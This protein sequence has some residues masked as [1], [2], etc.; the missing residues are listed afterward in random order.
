MNKFQKSQSKKIKSCYS[1]EL[2]KGT[3]IDHKYIRKEGKRYVYEESSSKSKQNIATD[4]NR[5]YRNIDTISSENKDELLN[6]AIKWATNLITER[7][8]I[9]PKFTIKWG[10]TSNTFDNTIEIRFKNPYHLK[11]PEELY[12][13]ILHELCHVIDN[14]FGSTLNKFGVDITRPI[15]DNS[16]W[17]EIPLSTAP[18]VY[19]KDS[20]D[21]DFVISLQYALY[22]RINELTD[23]RKKFLIN[24]FPKLIDLKRV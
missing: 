13:T 1:D 19:A 16:N 6:D 21:E 4:S 18:T 10:E 17:K 14:S 7:L 2:E 3:H 11:Y 5:V 22:G 9:S 8:D 15:S 23:D 12:D 20:K 24:K